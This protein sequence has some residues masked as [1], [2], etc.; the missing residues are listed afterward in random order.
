MT[1]AAD[2]LRCR[3]PY[4]G[5]QE[6]LQK[7]ARVHRE[8]LDRTHGWLLNNQFYCCC[9]TEPQPS[10]LATGTTANEATQSEIT[11]LASRDH[12]VVVARVSPQQLV[13]QFE[14]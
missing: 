4:K 5:K 12:Q 11:A 13:F 2:T 6:A 8:D 10:L 1:E 14:L 3:G 9:L 7:H